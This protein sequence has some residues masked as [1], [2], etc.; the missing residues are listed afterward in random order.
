MLV[1]SNYEENSLTI[2]PLEGYLMDEYHSTIRGFAA[3]VDSLAP[4]G[5]VNQ[6]LDPQERRGREAGVPAPK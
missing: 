3:Y 6:I 1:T 2:A 5:S 4:S